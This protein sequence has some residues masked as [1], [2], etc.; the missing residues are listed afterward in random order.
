MRLGYCHTLEVYF[1]PKTAN[2]NAALLLEE[3]I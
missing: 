3:K 1:L 2:E